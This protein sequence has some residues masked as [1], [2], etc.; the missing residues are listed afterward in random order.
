M[1][2][3][4]GLKMKGRAEIEGGLAIKVR[5]TL[6]GRRETSWRMGEVVA[7]FVDVEDF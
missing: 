2:T 4:R 7:I 3:Y 5:P 1:E 6:K